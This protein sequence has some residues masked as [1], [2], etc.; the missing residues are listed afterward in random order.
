MNIN[1]PTARMTFT[2][3]GRGAFSRAKNRHFRNAAAFNLTTGFRSDP[4][5]VTADALTIGANIQ[6][7]PGAAENPNSWTFNFVQICEIVQQNLHYAGR[8]KTDGSIVITAHL[9]PAL[10]QNVLL[11]SMTGI[12]PFTT[13][14]PA[15]FDPGPP[16]RYSN[17]MTDH[18]ISWFDIG[19]ENRETKKINWLVEAQEFRRFWTI[20]TVRDP[21]GR[22]DYLGYIRWALFYSGRVVHTSSS[23]QPIVTSTILSPQPFRSGRPPEPQVQALLNRPAAPFLN[24]EYGK[25]WVTALTNSNTSNRSDL[26]RRQTIP[27]STFS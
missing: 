8:Q 22:L 9:P 27:P 16:P 15:S 24:N 26:K 12:D 21:Q 17:L 1:K 13:S 18:P 14:S 7:T 5:G 6:A 10:S 2:N 19:D 11:D 23:Y 20:F 3:N 25:M 4:V